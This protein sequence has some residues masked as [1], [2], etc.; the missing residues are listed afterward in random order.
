[1]KRNNINRIFKLGLSALLIAFV[2]SSCVKSVSGRTDFE[3][4]QP[5]V[6]LAEG[7]L[8]NLAHRPLHCLR[9]MNQI[10]YIFT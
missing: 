5:T 9:L 7:G 3:G 2:G 8:A 6:L 1:M 10:H 4:L